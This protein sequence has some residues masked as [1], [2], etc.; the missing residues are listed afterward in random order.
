MRNRYPD[1]PGRDDGAPDNPLAMRAAA[2]R[3]SIAPIRPRGLTN[4]Q[5]LLGEGRFFGLCPV[6]DG[7]TYGFG[8]IT[9]PR[10]HEPIVGRL[11]RLRHH[12]VGFAEIVQ[13][14]LRALTSDEQ[15]HCGPIDWVA[16]D[17]W[18]VGRVILI[19]DAAHASSPMMGQGGCMAMED[20][21]VLAEK[22]VNCSSL[23]EA[24][25]SFVARRLPRVRWVH[26]ESTAVAASFRLP[27]N[28]RNDAL[29][30]VGAQMFQTRFRPLVTEP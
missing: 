4:L 5:F 16:L 29:R 8:N 10:T 27:P 17:Q 22:L 19:G 15:I 26:Q 14:Y 1:M 9:G 3:R 20:A 7:R 2:L 30:Q 12:F 11:D 24:L 6:A 13:D 25:A 18:H 28:V 21:W 23:P